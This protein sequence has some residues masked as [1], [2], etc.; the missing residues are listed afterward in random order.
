MNMTVFI[1]L[2]PLVNTTHIINQFTA[3]FNIQKNTS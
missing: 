1:F 2:L 3:L